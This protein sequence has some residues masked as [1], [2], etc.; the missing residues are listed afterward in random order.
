[1]QSFFGSIK[2]RQLKKSTE[3]TWSLGTLFIQKA[4]KITPVMKNSQSG[5]FGRHLG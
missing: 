1:V 3:N 4:L 2:S 5:P